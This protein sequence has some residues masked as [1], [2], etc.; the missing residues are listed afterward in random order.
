L[1]QKHGRFSCTFFFKFCFGSYEFSINNVFSWKVI[2]FEA[3][4]KEEEVLNSNLMNISRCIELLWDWSWKDNLQNG[5]YWMIIL[6][7]FPLF[8]NF[9]QAFPVKKD[10]VKQIISFLLMNFDFKRSL[11]NFALLCSFKSLNGALQA[12]EIFQYSNYPY[13]GGF[14][15]WW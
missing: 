14:S 9:F 7:S 10:L 11:I 13:I 12:L 3:R 4:T 15:A 5:Q 2:L 1:E 6:L 8:L